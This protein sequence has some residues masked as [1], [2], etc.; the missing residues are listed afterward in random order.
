MNSISNRSDLERLNRL[1]TRT[2]DP[3]PNPGTKLD[4]ELSN[5]ADSEKRESEEQT[6]KDLI[7]ILCNGIFSRVDEAQA[8]KIIGACL[9][10]FSGDKKELA[11]FLESKL[12]GGHTPFFYIIANRQFQIGQSAGSS[13]QGMPP[14]L[15]GLLG[16]CKEISK[17]AQRDMLQALYQG[18][19]N[20]LFQ[21]LRPY[22]SHFD[23]IPPKSFFDGEED[24]P[25]FTVTTISDQTFT[26]AFKIP[27]FYDRM[28]IDSVV[29]TYFLAS[30]QRWSLKRLQSA[31]YGNSF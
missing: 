28:L 30:G 29:S 12:L 13:K 18:S 21:S 23:M 2:T 16:I 9:R 27:R 17:E 8:N 26:V 14:L 10:L 3:I 19:S 11:Q 22:L 6:K 4:E 7:A 15:R 31:H 20:E 1:V 5:E 24:Q 25:T